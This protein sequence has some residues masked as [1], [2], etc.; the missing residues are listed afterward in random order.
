MPLLFIFRRVILSRGVPLQLPLCVTASSGG[1]QRL[2]V[3]HRSGVQEGHRVPRR[4]LSLLHQQL[5]RVPPGA[6]VPAVLAPAATALADRRQPG[7]PAAEGR[8]GRRLGV[9]HGRRAQGRGRRLDGLLH[10]CQRR[11]VR[12]RLVAL[13]RQQLPALGRRLH[14]AAAQRAR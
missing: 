5:P 10:G 6:G 9:P 1:G 4:V 8:T 14:V 11:R 3:R 2:D 7:G 13:L 12:P